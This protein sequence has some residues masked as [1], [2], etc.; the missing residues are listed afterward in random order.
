VTEANTECPEVGPYFP[1]T[2]G[3]AVQMGMTRNSDILLAP[4]WILIGSVI[5]GAVGVMLLIIVALV[6]LLYL[7]A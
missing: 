7:F 1:F 3:T 6:R 2:P 4:D 5:A